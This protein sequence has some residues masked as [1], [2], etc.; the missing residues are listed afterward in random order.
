MRF[1]Y[2]SIYILYSFSVVSWQNNSK[3]FLLSSTTYIGKL[4][5]YLSSW[6]SNTDDLFD[7]ED[8][9]D[10]A[11][12]LS[13]YYPEIFDFNF[14]APGIFPVAFSICTEGLSASE[15][16]FRV[17]RLSSMFFSLIE[18]ICKDALNLYLS[19]LILVISYWTDMAS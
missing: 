14:P 9:L 16:C 2:S 6:S 11:L 4:Y 7:V 5:V 18:S 10:I 3:D 19:A 17:C 13:L 12:N 1:D 8:F 15:G